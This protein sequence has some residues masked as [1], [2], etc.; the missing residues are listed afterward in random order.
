MTVPMSNGPPA[1]NKQPINFKK[2][3]KAAP[4]PK[5][6]RFIG[7]ENSH[8]LTV[9]A[10]LMRRPISHQE[11]DSLAGGANGL[12]LVTDLRDKG[13]AITC[14]RIEFLD[15]NGDPFSADV[16]SFPAKVKRLIN[17]WL[18]KRKTGGLA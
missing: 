8:E 2:R 9:I 17:K 11:L 10:T 6:P 4:I 3:Y 18:A 15:T 14:D 5:P 7:T 16:F 1:A 12:A 13:L